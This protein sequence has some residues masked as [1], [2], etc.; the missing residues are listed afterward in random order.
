MWKRCNPR[1]KNQADRLPHTTNTILQRRSLDCEKRGRRKVR[2][3]RVVEIITRM[4]KSKELVS[5]VKT[6]KLQYLEHITTEDKYHLLQVVMQG[7]MQGRR[8]DGRRRQSQM[9]IPR[10]GNIDQL[11]RA[12]LSK[13]SIEMMIVN[14][15]SGEGA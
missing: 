14:L 9:R 10:E 4:K 8:S 1:I 15:R 7:K 12:A 13:I 5:I 3:T 2:G 6:R 11:F